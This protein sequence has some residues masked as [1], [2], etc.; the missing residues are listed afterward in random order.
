MRKILTAFIVLTLV[1]TSV[2]CF[3]CKKTDEP[4]ST[5]DPVVVNVTFTYN[6]KVTDALDAYA[7]AHDDFTFNHTFNTV[8]NSESVTLVKS[9]DVEIVDNYATNTYITY[10]INKKDAT[11]ID[12]AVDPILYNDEEFYLT[13]VTVEKL[14]ADDTLK[15][16]FVTT[17]WDG[18]FTASEVNSTPAI[19]IT[20]AHA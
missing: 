11:L 10:Y 4:V 5:I 8:Y 19:V 15:I 3:G 6:Q 7:T 9:G 13:L 14:N 17:T 20:F 16:A 1:I 2:F 18:N 12:A